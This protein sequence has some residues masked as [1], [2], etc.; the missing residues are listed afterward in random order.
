M[1]IRDSPATVLTRNNRER[2]WEKTAERKGK[3]KTNN[4]ICERANRDT[5]MIAGREEETRKKA[6]EEGGRS[7]ETASPRGWYF[8][9]FRGK[10]YEKLR[11]K[12]SARRSWNRI[13]KLAKPIKA[14]RESL[15]DSSR[16]RVSFPGAR[17]PLFFYYV[18]FRLVA[19]LGAI[20]LFALPYK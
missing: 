10:E 19:E 1:N 3:M 20:K 7:F 14:F 6:E 15:R 11:A 9:F 8:F 17:R 18:A 5:G 13:K 12:I 16:K 4:G 2:R